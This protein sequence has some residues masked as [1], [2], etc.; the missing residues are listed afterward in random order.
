[1]QPVLHKNPH[2]MNEE[3]HMN[4]RMT[5]GDNIAVLTH[6]FQPSEAHLELFV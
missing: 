3:N 4:D 2:S 6:K 1:M 5:V